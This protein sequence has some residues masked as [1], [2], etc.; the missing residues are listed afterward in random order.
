MER[1]CDLLCVDCLNLGLN[2][3]NNHVRFTEIKQTSK[4][5]NLI[6]DL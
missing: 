1:M 3:T 4:T 6:Y 2:N 5:H